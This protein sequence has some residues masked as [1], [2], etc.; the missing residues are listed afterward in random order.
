MK[1]SVELWQEVGVPRE[2]KLETVEGPNAAPG[3]MLQLQVGSIVP[4]YRVHRNDLLEF[5]EATAAFLRAQKER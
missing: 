1:L 4:P 2:L 5:C 3:D